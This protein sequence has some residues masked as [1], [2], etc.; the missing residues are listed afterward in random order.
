M[1][2]L[3]GL[4]GLSRML[5]R[6][7]VEA[8]LSELEKIENTTVGNL[9]AFMHSYNLRFAAGHDRPSSGR[10]IRRSIR[11]SPHLARQGPRQAG[12]RDAQAEQH[13]RRHP[14]PGPRPGAD[15]DLQRDGRDKHLNPRATPKTPPK[16]L[17]E[18][19]SR[20]TPGDRRPGRRSPIDVPGPDAA[21]RRPGLVDSPT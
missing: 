12:R 4:A 11:S 21:T 16:P 13:Q 3:K 8:V 20:S 5:E 14:A 1:N 10:P 15:G 19:A 17:I 7:N 6:P 18:A 2:Y 9:V